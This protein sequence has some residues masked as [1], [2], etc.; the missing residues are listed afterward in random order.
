MA[1]T[2]TL[3]PTRAMSTSELSHF[4]LAILQAPAHHH[5]HVLFLLFSCTCICNQAPIT[6]TRSA[7]VCECTVQYVRVCA[8]IYGEDECMLDLEQRCEAVDEPVYEW[9]DDFGGRKDRVGDAILDPEL[10]G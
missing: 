8:R 4:S 1:W 5:T 10:E 2:G 6:D 7:W 3:V 9:V